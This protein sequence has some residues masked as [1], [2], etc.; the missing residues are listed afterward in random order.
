MAGDERQRV[1]RF[2]NPCAPIHI[3]HASLPHWRQDGVIYFVTFRLVDS[4]PR[5]RLVG[6]LQERSHWLAEHPEPWSEDEWEAYHKRFSG[7]LEKWL[8]QSSGSCVLRLPECQH[9]VASALRR[10]AGKR[11]LLGESVVA[12]NHVHA[13][14]TP[15]P[16]HVLSGIIQGWKSFTAKQIGRM[17]AA[18][19]RLGEWWDGYHTRRCERAERD[20]SGSAA[21][22]AYQRPV[23]QKETYDHIVRSAPALSRIEAYIRSHPSW[24]G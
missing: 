8:D 22:I 3:T 2:L 4:L 16:G 24:R 21:A 6:W 11:Y 7:R 23:W 19:R 1:P 5:A 12:P 17:D 9:V 10:F 14:V 20:H 18:A 13:L 15:L